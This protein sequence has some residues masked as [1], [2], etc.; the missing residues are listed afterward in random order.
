MNAVALAVLFTGLT[1]TAAPAGAQETVGKR[2]VRGDVSA[3]IGWLH[4]N[5]GELDAYDEWDNRGLS[6]DLGF[7]WYW[8]DHIKSEIQ[9]EV[10]HEMTAYVS[11]RVDTGGPPLFTS[12]QYA[13]ATR[14][15]SLIQQYQ[16]GRNQWFH[17]FIG[18]GLQVVR[19]RTSREDMPLYSFDQVTRQ[20]RIVRE[21]LVHP[22]RT[23][24]TT[25]ALISG[26]F[27][28]Y[29]ARRAFFLTD[30]RL[31]F[32]GRPEEVLVRIGM[33]IDF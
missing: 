6:G 16:F 4:V 1:A 26:G 17:P 7:G 28:A 25:H 23:Q 33:G 3:T 29:V 32:T 20:T 31:A 8:T 2:L 22:V 15:F 19:E 30:V 12:S 27:K 24:V 10:A 14:R 18:G 21:A 11:T 13:F 5:R 9:A